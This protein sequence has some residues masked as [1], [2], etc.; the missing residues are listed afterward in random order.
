[1][2]KAK[3]LIVEDEAITAKDIQNGLNG[4]DIPIVYFSAYIDEESQ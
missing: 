3:I 2:E 4:F 1:M